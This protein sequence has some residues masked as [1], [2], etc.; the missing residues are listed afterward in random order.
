M[1]LLTIRNATKICVWLCLLSLHVNMGCNR[2]RSHKMLA[3]NN[4]V[5]QIS[6]ETVDGINKYSARLVNRTGTRAVLE[7][8]HSGGGYIHERPEIGYRIQRLTTGGSWE[9]VITNLNN[10]G[11]DA[12]A[13]DSGESILIFD[14]DPLQ[15][16]TFLRRGDILRVE[17]FLQFSSSAPV[18]VSE[19]FTL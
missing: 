12:V 9:T 16:R 7:A 6:V 17:A 18:A 15:Q 2:E 11:N 8:L 5:V 3:N 19:Q 14:D 1:T 13:V 4:W 10:K